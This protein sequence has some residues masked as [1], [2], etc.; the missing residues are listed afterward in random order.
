MMAINPLSL[1]EQLEIAI[2]EEILDGKLLPGQRLSLNELAQRWDVSNMP[3]R[4]AVRRLESSGFLVV[5]PRSGI[6]V[7]EFDKDRFKNILNIR[8]ALECL[9]VELSIGSIPNIEIEEA[10][11]VYQD[12]R[13]ELEDTGDITA[14]QNHDNLVH[15]LIFKYCAN[16]ELIETMRGIQ[17][18]IDWG[19]RI[20]AASNP[21]ALIHAL[22]EHLAILD[23]LKQRNT[24]EA[25][26]AMQSH[27]QNTLHRTFE[28]WE[29]DDPK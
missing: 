13:K 15:Q 9:A 10:T 3:V 27:L 29:K 1:G 12:A 22:P 21:D 7:A 6:Y 23:A 17:H 2:R 8:I 4:D 18:L 25:K 16:P 20:S 14:L 5:V 19:H 24:E 26:A 28:G 11:M